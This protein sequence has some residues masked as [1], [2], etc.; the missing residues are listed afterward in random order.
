MSLPP[1]Q[2][3]SFSDLW[4]TPVGEVEFLFERA[5]TEGTP[6]ILKRAT[7]LMLVRILRLLREGSRQEILEEALA[8]SRGISSEAGRALQ[9]RSPETFGAWSAMD[10]LLAEAGRRSDRAA[11]PSLLRSTRGHGLA[12][13]ELLAAEGRAVPRAEIRRRRDLPEAHLSHLLRDLEEADLI[14]R[15]RT[16][17]S[18]EVLVELGPA[19]REVVSQSILP[20]WL[21]RLTAALAEIGG[22]A[23]PDSETLVQELQEAGAPSR[24]VAERLAAALGQLVPASLATAPNQERSNVLPFVRGV[25]NLR[26]NGEYH[27]QEMQDRLDGRQARALFNVEPAASSG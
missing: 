17:G 13:L 26:E 19:G 25:S 7:S 27:F 4:D 18:K 23:S 22:G 16:Q 1:L 10:D 15:Y 9:E 12:I 20:P 11:V 5:A 24:L 3:S 8:V 21:E 2:S 14:L 6:E